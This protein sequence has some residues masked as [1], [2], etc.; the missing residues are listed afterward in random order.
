MECCADDEHL[1][2]D[3]P[4]FYNPPSLL[5]SSLFL[6]LSEFDNSSS[7]ANMSS[8]PGQWASRVFRIR[9]PIHS[10]AC[11]QAGVGN[12]CVCCELEQSR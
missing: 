1:D 2:Q 8:G 9:T 11:S 5:F 12:E 6:S 7:S 10:C 3:R 4:V